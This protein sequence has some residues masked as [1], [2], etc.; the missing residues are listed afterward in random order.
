MQLR[1]PYNEGKVQVVKS[2]AEWTLT[3]KN[4]RRLGFYSYPTLETP[5]NGIILDGQSFSDPLPSLPNHFCRLNTQ[6]QICDG[7]YEQTERSPL[8]YGPAIQVIDGPLLFIYGT[9]VNFK[10]ISVEY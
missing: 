10:E 3:T 9:T 4:V 6:W 5:Q 7:S 2:S 8:T 1:L